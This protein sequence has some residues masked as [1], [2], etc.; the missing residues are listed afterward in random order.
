[1]NVEQTKYTELINKIG[2]LLQQG[3]EQVA[4]SASTILVQTYWLIG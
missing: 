4:R 3:R 1:M 2:D